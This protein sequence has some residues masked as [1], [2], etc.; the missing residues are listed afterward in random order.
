MCERVGVVNI[1]H[2]IAAWQFSQF[3]GLEYWFELAILIDEVQGRSQL[4][5]GTFIV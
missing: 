1:H 5:V 3:R 4:T 2:L